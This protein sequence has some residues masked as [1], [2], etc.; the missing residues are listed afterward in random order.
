MSAESGSGGTG[1]SAGPSPPERGRA[2][3]RRKLGV[4][5][6]AVLLL[7]AADLSRPPD[8]Q[9]SA[10]ALLASIDLYQATL[11]PRLGSLGVSCRFTPS[12]SRYAEGAI[13]RDGALV[14]SLRAAGRLARC[15]P[16]T[17]PGT[18]DPP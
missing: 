18:H 3:R 1:A 6:A 16:W 11:S 10:R 12:C 2:A 17:P 7:A 4:A 15:G 5:A 8:H 14:G 13:R 9:L